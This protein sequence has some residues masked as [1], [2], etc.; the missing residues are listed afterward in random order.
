MRVAR[1]PGTEWMNSPEKITVR[2]GPSVEVEP[3]NHP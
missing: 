3:S 2:G 1:L